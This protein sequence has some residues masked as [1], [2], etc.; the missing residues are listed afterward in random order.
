MPNKAVVVTSLAVPLILVVLALTACGDSEAEARAKAICDTVTEGEPFKDAAG[1]IR[2]SS[3]GDKKV[4]TEKQVVV[5][6][7]EFAYSRITCSFDN[8]EGRVANKRFFHL[9]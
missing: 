9:D 8:I 6:F 4:V 2:E 3:S 7:V 5:V 1:R